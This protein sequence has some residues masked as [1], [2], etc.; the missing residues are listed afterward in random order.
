MARSKRAQDSG[1]PCLTPCV[2]LKGLLK[3]LFIAT[4]VFALVYRVFTVLVKVLGRPTLS[5]VAQR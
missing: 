1:S 2:T 3:T 5:M 4:M